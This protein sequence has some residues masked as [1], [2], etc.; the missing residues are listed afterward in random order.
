VSDLY[1][2]RYIIGN[3]VEMCKWKEGEENTKKGNEKTDAYE[4]R[5]GKQE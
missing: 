1:V 3:M 2:I 4:K 5:I